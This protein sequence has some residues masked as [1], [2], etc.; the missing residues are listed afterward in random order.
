MG[1]VVQRAWGGR[2]LALE[3]MGLDAGELL[4]LGVSDVFDESTIP[5]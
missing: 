3:G 1:E 2:V 5:P 4:R